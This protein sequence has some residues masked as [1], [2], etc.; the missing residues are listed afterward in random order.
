MYESEQKK[1]LNLLFE[2]RYEYGI[3]ISKV[4]NWDKEILSSL[5]N[6]KFISKDYL[7]SKV[8]LRFCK[9]WKNNLMEYDLTLENNFKH[10]FF[11]IKKVFDL[12]Y[13][14]FY[15][16]N[17][18]IK[19]IEEL[20]KIKIF[21]Y[22]KGYEIS[23]FEKLFINLSEIYSSDSNY[24]NFSKLLEIIPEDKFIDVVNL[25]V[26][27]NYNLNFDENI[28]VSRLLKIKSKNEVEIFIENLSAKLKNKYKFSFYRLLEDKEISDVDV[29][30]LVK[31]YLENDDFS[32]VP[33]S[34]DFLLKYIKIDADIIIKISRILLEKS[35]IENRFLN[36]F[37]L[38][39]NPY[40]EI[41]QN[42]I[43]FFKNNFDLLKSIY[44]KLNIYFNHFDYDSET[45]DQILDIEPNF[46]LE[47]LKCEDKNKSHRK[48]NRL[49]E[50]IDY[51]K[52]VT[53]VTKYFYENQDKNNINSNLGL[54]FDI[55]EFTDEENKLE[56]KQIQYLKF[57]IKENIEDNEKIEFIFED[58]ISSLSNEHRKLLIKYIV[59][60]DIKFE[61]FKELSLEKSF[62]SWQGSAVPMYQKRIE[63]F[64]SL[65]ELFEGIKYLEFKK[66]IEQII[67]WKKEDIKRE[68]KSDFIDDF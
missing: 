51:K 18:D 40:T 10:E 49:W 32:I 7:E 62:M 41:N 65:L 61:I 52:I 53:V 43:S 9:L 56:E 3:G 13:S 23:D 22:I 19:Q 46:I 24:S 50:R 45:L 15:S 29:K 1:V 60:L 66:Y 37:E 38:F 27:N 58:I 36:G 26:L 11:Q 16:D 57:F 42:I 39:F 67:E 64:E 68:K 4:E 30:N 28:I 17:K 44:L 8:V 63:F 34:T 5:I 21:E 54:F 20:I 33:F 12:S 25:I 35:N 48:Y 14:D 47:Y 55:S 6:E 31:L 2:Y 59:D